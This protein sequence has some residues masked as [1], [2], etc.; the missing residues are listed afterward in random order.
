MPSFE[1]VAPGA[2]A[3]LRLPVGLTYEQLLIKY[4]GATLAQLTEIRVVA[5]GKTI[6][7]Y[8][9]GGSRLDLLNKFEG[10]A[11]AAGTIVLDFNRFGL[12]TREAEELT[13]LGT[14]I[15][16][17]E[18]FPVT[19]STLAVEVDIA[20]AAVGPALSARAIQSAPRPLGLLKHIREYTYQAP[21]VGEYEISDLPKG[22]LIGKILF[23][24]ANIAA[25]RIERDNF[26]V[27]E[28]TAAENSQI[29]TDGIR[30]PQAG[31]FVFDPAEAGLGSEALETLGVND[32][33][34]KLTMSAAGAVPVTVEALAPLGV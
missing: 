2:T 14:G 18:Q 33:R 6:H 23:H 8:A 3:T 29:Q 4:S 32:L 10:R 22:P 19:I 1:G 26:T 30:V 17:N 5:N 11:A 16:P 12:R 20:G 21:A 25:V 7:R 24:S 28:R 27:F 13:A 15:A 31:V 34:F 9:G